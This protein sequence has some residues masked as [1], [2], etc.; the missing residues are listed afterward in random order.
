VNH[1]AI[2]LLSGAT[3][4]VLLAFTGPLAGLGAGR[5]VASGD[6]DGDGLLDLIVAAPAVS[7]LQAGVT[8]VVSAQDG[9][10]LNTVGV[11]VPG[12]YGS[13]VAQVGDVDLDGR[14]DLV[15]GG[16]GVVHAWHGLHKTGA[17]TLTID[18]TLQPDS[19]FVVTVEG[20]EPDT[21]GL[22]LI[23]FTKLDLPA[24]GGVLVPSLN[25][26]V[27]FATAVAGGST[28]EGRWPAA[29]P[30]FWSL[31]MQAWIVDP[32]G[33]QGFTATNGWSVSTD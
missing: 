31:W 24:L 30:S 27:P 7:A 21:T 14:D 20:A 3:G 18:T 25:L 16:K 23:G 4:A 10:L 29:A 15:T 9:T 13:L 6:V 33:P 1:G 12:A 22:L 32:Q 8:F 28:L 19:P 5:S 2:S 11:G 26:L 17:P